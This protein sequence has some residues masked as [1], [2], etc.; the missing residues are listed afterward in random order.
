MKKTLLL[1]TT[2]IVSAFAL[3]VKANAPTVEI[4]AKANVVS[5][6][7]LESIQELDFGT[8]AY[9]PGARY[10]VSKDGT[11]E[12]IGD[13]AQMFGTPS[14]GK[15]KLRTDVTGAGEHY[16]L[17][18]PHEM[19]LKFGE[20]TCGTVSAFSQATPTFAKVV[21]GVSEYEIAFGGTFIM[22]DTLS[23][24]AHNDGAVCTGS[25]TATLVYKD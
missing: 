23:E 4:H 18:L 25:A 7:V 10:T 20:Q 24:T 19:E 1:A 3:N 21:D 14:V 17:S 12:A 6:S 22:S 16:S 9:Y 8:V 2:A 11:A 5:P 15:I 13:Y